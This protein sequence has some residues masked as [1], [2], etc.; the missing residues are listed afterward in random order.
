LT[1][2]STIIGSRPNLRKVTADFPF[3]RVPIAAVI[4]Q[5]LDLVNGD[6]HPIESFSETVTASGR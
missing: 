3:P 6:F 1:V 2:L 5:A 4:G